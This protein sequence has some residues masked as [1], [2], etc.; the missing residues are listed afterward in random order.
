MKELLKVANRL[1]KLLDEGA[2]ILPHC[3]RHREL[4][5]AISHAEQQMEDDAQHKRV[6]PT[7]NVTRTNLNLALRMVNIQ[8]SEGLLD[9]V[10]DVVELIERKGDDVSIMD[11]CELQRTWEV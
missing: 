2:Q 5:A 10:V 6:K 11:I 3:L 7:N 1:D 9:Q 8:I 4:S